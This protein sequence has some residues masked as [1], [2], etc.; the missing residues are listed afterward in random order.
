[1]RSYATLALFG[2]MVIAPVFG[3]DNR[4]DRLLNS[5]PQP[6]KIPLPDATHIPIVFGKD[7][8][9]KGESGER[10]ALLF[11]DPTK[12]GIYGILIKW[13]PGHYSK[14]HF[15]STDRYIYVVEGTWW[16]SSSTTWDPTKTYPVPAGSYVRDLPG[17]VHWDG[18]K[19]EP[20]LLMLVGMGPMV[21]THLPEPEG[22]KK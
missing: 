2:L 13:E 9:W 10:Q 4:L 20:C 5:G 21:T 8:Q 22:D 14:P 6:T 15:H 12:A 7:I 19:E 11:G 3:G 16:V 1:M 17:T 18:A